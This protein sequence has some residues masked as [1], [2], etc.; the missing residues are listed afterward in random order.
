MDRAQARVACERSRMAFP[1]GCAEAGQKRNPRGVTN[2]SPSREHTRRPPFSRGGG[3][4]VVLRWLPASWLTRVAGKLAG[5]TLPTSLR[6]PACRLFG[7]VLGVDFSEVRD[8]LSSFRSLQDFFTRALRPGLRPVDPAADAVVSPCDGAWGASGRV[9]RGMLLQLKGRSYALSELI[10]EPSLAE[11][12]EGGAYATFYLSPSDY[13]RFHA[14]C[15]AWVRRAVHVPGSLWPVSGIGLEGVDGLFARNERLVAQMDLRQDESGDASPALCVVAVGAML[16]G[17]VR[18]TFDDL[19][20]R[21][22]ASLSPVRDYPVPGIALKKG[23]EWGRFEFG[24]TLI[25]V[26]AAGFMELESRPPGTPIRLGE[27]IGRLMAERA[28]PV[29]PSR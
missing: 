1:G 13:H 10:A 4:L 9:E 29:D 25:I 21:R 6:A 14:P 17:K 15:D 23:V 16:V 18:L 2:S 24:S 26:A 11:R 12:L 28:R 27:R 19:A 22:R 8:P 20:T 3:W 7:R 5:L